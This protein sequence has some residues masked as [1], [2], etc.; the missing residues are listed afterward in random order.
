MSSFLIFPACRRIRPRSTTLPVHVP[1]P[2]N[3]HRPG[4]L[5]EPH[6]E[7]RLL[8]LVVTETKTPRSRRLVTLSPTAERLLRE[9]RANQR[10]ERLSAGSM[11]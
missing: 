7:R 6:N 10:G 3:D 1:G 5:N 4:T 11:W 8:P 9:V 2:I